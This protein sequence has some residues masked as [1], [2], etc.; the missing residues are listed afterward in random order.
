MPRHE[1]D[2]A[3]EASGT[4]ASLAATAGVGERNGDRA[5]VPRP[6]R[7]VATPHGWIVADALAGR[8]AI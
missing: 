1:G 8:P 2:D 7:S 4:I 6:I 5:L 3:A